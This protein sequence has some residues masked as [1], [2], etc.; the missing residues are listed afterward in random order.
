MTLLFSSLLKVPD[1]QEL[2]SGRHVCK[3]EDDHDDDL[4]QLHGEEGH[5]DGDQHQLDGEEVH[6]KVERPHCTPQAHWR[7]NGDCKNLE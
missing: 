6:P 1:K 3:S 2:K 7:R 5:L 4:H